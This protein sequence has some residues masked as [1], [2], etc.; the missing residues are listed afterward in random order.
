MVRLI[1]TVLVLVCS[2]VFGQDGKFEQGM[3]KA[4]GVWK[5][6][7]SAEASALFERIATAEKANWLP[8]YYVALINCTEAFKPENREKSTTLIEKA[9]TALNNAGSKSQNNAEINVMQALI[10]TA[11]LVQDPMTNGMKYTMLANGE[12]AKAKAIAP[13]NPRVVFC[14]AEFALGGAKW[15]GADTQPICAEVSRSIDLFANFKPESSFHPNWGLDRAK[16]T[17]ENCK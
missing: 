11:T 10:Y 17:A 13:N 3:G 16:Q 1:T 7:K 9:Q 5:E 12:Y 8:D 2:A 4:F 15:S 6:G 14:C